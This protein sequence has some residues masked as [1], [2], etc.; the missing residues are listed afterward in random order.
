MA[1]S[2]P[3]RREPTRR[4]RVQYRQSQLKRYFQRWLTRRSMDEVFPNIYLGGYVLQSYSKHPTIY[5]NNPPAPTQP[6]TWTF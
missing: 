4:E 1:N 6:K 2:E 5:P 3:A